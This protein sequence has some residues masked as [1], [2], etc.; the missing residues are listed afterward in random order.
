MIGPLG[1]NLIFIL[2][3]PRSGSTMLQRVLAGSCEIHTMSEPWIA[4]APAFALRSGG[5]RSYNSDAGA[6]A[7]HDFLSHIPDGTNVYSRAVRAMLIHL[8]TS[9]LAPSGKRCFLDKTPRYYHII[10]ELRQFFPAA[11]FVFLLRNPLEVLASMLETWGDLEFDNPHNQR[12]LFV[13]PQL[14]LNSLSEG[15]VVRYEN[16]VKAPEATVSDLCRF[17]GV[18][19]EPEMVN[20]GS[21]PPLRGRFGDPTGV[22]LYSSPVVNNL[23]KWRTTLASDLRYALACGYLAKLDTDVCEG[24]GYPKKML[25]RDLTSLRN[26]C[27]LE[28]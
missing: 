24:L 5:N 2:S 28:Q 27:N 16:L 20:Y 22:M 1:E 7:T 21:R 14:L 18:R 23:H 3:Q 4:L 6:E 19:F 12:D 8:Y 15:T 26:P 11:K 9:A 10:P 25:A 13:A 17:L